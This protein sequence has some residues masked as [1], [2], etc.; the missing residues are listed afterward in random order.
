MC[1]AKHGSDRDY[2]FTVTALREYLITEAELR[3]SVMTKLTPKLRASVDTK[4]IPKTDA[5]GQFYRGPKTDRFA[6]FL[7][8]VLP[9]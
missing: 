8:S 4:L 5:R 3:A 9:Y 6:Q 1:G 2:R 7:R